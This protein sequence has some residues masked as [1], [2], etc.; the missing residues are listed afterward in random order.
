MK[1]GRWNAIEVCIAIALAGTLAAV[2]VPRFFAEVRTEKVAEASGNLRIL[3]DRVAA[4]YAAVHRTPAGLL[5]RCLPSSAGPTPPMP[6][7]SPVAYD[8][9]AAASPGAATWKDLGFSP[10]KVRYRY[11]FATTASGCDLRAAMIFLRAEGDLDGDGT[12]SLFE[13]RA[14]IDPKAATVVPFGGLFIQDRPE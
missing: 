2:F 5:T 6:S 10:A 1:G 11:A 8:F 4:Y 12:R 7:T 9:A 3:E 14:R 13:R